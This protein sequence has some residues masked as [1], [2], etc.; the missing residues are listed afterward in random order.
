MLLNRIIFAV[1]LLTSTT[2][3]SH[4][5][6]V[7]VEST[8]TITSTI[9]DNSPLIPQTEHAV[10]FS[11]LQH[12]PESS[13]DDQENMDLHTDTP[14]SISC[15][16][17]S[18]HASPESSSLSNL[19][20]SADLDEE[21][22]YEEGH[23][24]DDPT[25]PFLILR[26]NYDMAKDAVM[27]GYAV[28]A[29]LPEDGRTALDLVAEQIDFDLAVFLMN[30]GAVFSPLGRKMIVEYY[31]AD[32]Q[33]TSASLLYMVYDKYSDDEDLFDLL[34]EANADPNAYETK[35]GKT[36]LHLAA[37][38]NDVRAMEI[39]I[40]KNASVNKKAEQ[41]E[42][43]LHYAA[44]NCNFEAV[45]LLIEHD[46]DPLEFNRYGQKPSGLIRDETLP[47][48]MRVKRFLSEKE[49]EIDL[50]SPDSP[51]FS[52]TRP[53]RAFSMPIPIS[54]ENSARLSGRPEHAPSPIM[55]MIGS[56]R[57]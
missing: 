7:I 8:G 34:V 21:D 25:V 13:I 54:R 24:S 40:N 26:R 2:L 15:L 30:H 43:P 19:K 31:N 16:R 6:P 11:P 53:Q 44:R 32:E 3:T 52:R 57:W 33:L 50:P 51:A 5:L 1:A 14:K 46:A 27:E 36:V 48:C 35:T 29:P 42:T 4:A 37:E 45:Q 47:E 39:L 17:I 18:P 22:L 23:P 9:V 55:K 49:E 28:N 20:L 38:R 12:K 56:D 41:N 10:N